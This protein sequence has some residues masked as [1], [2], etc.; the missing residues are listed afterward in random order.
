VGT[1]LVVRHGQASLFAADYD[2]LSP[3]G[4]TQ[5]RALGEFL[6]THGP[7]PDRVFAGPAKRQRD[8]ARLCGEAYTG[9][10]APWPEIEALPELDEHDAFR[11]LASVVPRMQ[12]DPEIAELAA[13]AAERGDPRVRS[14]AFQRLFE[15]VMRRWL[16]GELDDTSIESWP[17]FAARVERGLARLL[18][19]GGAGQRTV[20]F[21]S[22]GPLAVMLRAALGTSDLDS[23]RTAWRVRNASITT[24]VFRGREL[25]LD[26]FNALPHLPER[27]GWTFR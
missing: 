8:T 16:R 22:V 17:A 23:F 15:A 25:T 10:A 13:A 7:H 5:A 11:M 18:E 12:H 26:G 4:E 20:A 2:E 24:F 3:Q 1:L 27:S 6:R 21:T 14:A 19:P 9:A